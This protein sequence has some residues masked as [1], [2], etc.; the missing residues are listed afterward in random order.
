MPH[1]SIEY[2]RN[3][4]GILDIGALVDAL[5]SSAQGLNIFPPWGIRTFAAEIRTF[6]VAD[7]G[8]TGT[9]GYI[10][11]RVKVAGG[12]S[13]AVMQKIVDTFELALSTRIGSV[14]RA[15]P[16]GYQLEIFPFDPALTRSGGSIAGR[17][18]PS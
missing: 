8:L 1:I 3:I 13:D 2:T 6:R 10:H 9:N 15:Q 7:D 14:C 18:T 5:H 4:A 16:V 12:R 17:N 11:V